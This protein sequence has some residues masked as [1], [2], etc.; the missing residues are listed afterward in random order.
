MSV[1]A[2][3]VGGG[4]GRSFVWDIAFYYLSVCCSRIDR[5]ISRF[6]WASA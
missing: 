4:N 2:L 1:F 6:R 3:R 5:A